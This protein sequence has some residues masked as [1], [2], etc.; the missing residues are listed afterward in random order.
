MHLLKMGSLSVSDGNWNS[1]T[2]Y[3]EAVYQ[4]Y[5]YL[6]LIILTFFPCD[7]LRNIERTVCLILEMTG[8]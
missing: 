3:F 6:S 7:N 2:D 4:D 5:C 1:K 8:R